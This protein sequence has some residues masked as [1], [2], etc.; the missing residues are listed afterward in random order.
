MAP[1]AMDASVALLPCKRGSRPKARAWVGERHNEI[2]GIHGLVFKCP[3]VARFRHDQPRGTRQHGNL[4]EAESSGQRKNI[5]C[6]WIRVSILTF[7]SVP[8]YS[9]PSIE[10]EVEPKTRPRYNSP[11]YK[12][13]SPTNE[14]EK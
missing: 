5:G 8:D 14:D 9:V 1:L 2:P 13:S 3:E 6:T 12:R 7:F 10:M 4:P 11:T